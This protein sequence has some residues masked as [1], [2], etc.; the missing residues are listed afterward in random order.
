M[1]L[2]ALV[3]LQVAIADSVWTYFSVSDDNQYSINAS[4]GTPPQPLTVNLDF[5]T[6]DL[7]VVPNRCSSGYC[8]NLLAGNAFNVSGSESLIMNSSAFSVEFTTGITISGM[9]AQDTFEFGGHSIDDLQMGIRTDT[10]DFY[11]Y[12][13][14]ISTALYITSSLGLGPPGLE[15]SV[16]YTT[17]DRRLEPQYKNFMQR[18]GSDVQRSFSIWV[19]P[20]ES[21]Q[22]LLV[23][24][25]MDP[26]YYEESSYAT[27][28]LLR[29]Y[30][31]NG[32]SE[33]GELS[34]ITFLY[35]QVYMDYLVPGESTSSPY[36][37]MDQTET[38]FNMR[39]KVLESDVEGIVK[40]DT[41]STFTMTADMLGN[42]T[43]TLRATWST[44]YEAYLLPC[45]TQALISIVIS[46]T[47]ALVLDLKDVLFDMD[48]ADAVGNELCTLNIDAGT[49]VVLSN[50]NL[51]KY[52]VAVDY[53]NEQ[54]SFAKPMNVSSGVLPSQIMPVSSASTQPTM[55]PLASLPTVS[56]PL[57]TYNY[58]NSTSLQL[59]KLPMVTAGAY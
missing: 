49:R 54:I 21:G 59:T 23:F 8:Q 51:K 1:L 42:L 56:V 29:L 43:Q 16:M 58:Q 26:Q 12:T 53:E 18:L 9:W 20:S 41:D 5:G 28:P 27:V 44:S 33:L 10:V 2:T 40:L 30:G 24:G 38:S 11:Y 32:E 13:S 35:Y 47:Y 17:P 52:F 15:C 37:L 4:I 45:N 48:I 34:D 14:N 7:L 19:D 50:T 6:A 25:G 57:A 46:S 36:N 22:G 3:Q 31:R 39:N 55:D